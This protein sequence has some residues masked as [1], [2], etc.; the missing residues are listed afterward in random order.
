ME[1][2]TRIGIAGAD[3]RMGKAL[4][5]AA[6]TDRDIEVT[7]AFGRSEAEAGGPPNSMLLA[8]DVLVDFSNPAGASQIAARLTA[9]SATLKAPAMVIGVTGLSPQEI[10]TVARA[11][12]VLAIVKSANFSIGVNV[13]LAVVKSAAAR[14][15]AGDWDIEIVDA[16]HRMKRNS[17]SGTALAFG[18]AAARG[19]GVSL[20]NARA[21]ERQP[22]SRLRVEGEIGF[23]S[24]RGGG[25]I[26][27]HA[28]LFAAEDE[29]LTISHSARSRSSFARGA[30]RAAKWVRQKRA[31]LYGMTDVLGDGLR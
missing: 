16:H 30:L 14:L 19:R 10:A 2:R 21:R 25:M 22:A 15:P 26:G 17:P 3:G 27:E 23:A 4:A 8:C 18:D 13:A 20:E 24:L 7:A 1:K 28:I 6:A 11:A 5:E 9:L 29:I 31:G 12:R